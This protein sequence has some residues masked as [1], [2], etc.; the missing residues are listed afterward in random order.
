M[1]DT[2]QTQNNT[3]LDTEF[4]NIVPWNGGFDTGRDVRLKWERNFE[5]IK[6]NFLNLV[7]SMAFNDEKYMRKD[8]PESTQFLLSLLGGAVF[9]EHGFA[10]GITGFGAKIDEKGY[11]EM[12]GLTLWEWLQVPELRYNRV[13]ILIGDKWRG[14]GGGII[15][16]CTPDTDAEGN[17]LDTGTATLKLE[18][19]EYGS[20]HLHDMNM[21]IYHFGDER[22]ATEDSD[23]GKGNFSFAGF[24]TSYFIITEVSDDN[25]G[26]FRY[27]LRA[28]YKIHPYPQM[29]FTCRGN[30]TYEDRMTVVYETRTYTRML[31]KLNT[32]E[33]GVQNIA[34]QFGDLTNLNV[35]GMFMD[36]YS[37]YL[38]SVYFTGTVAQVKPDGTPVMTAND[39]GAW[40]PDDNHADYYDRFSYKGSLWLCID[41]NGTDTTPSENN[42]SWLLQ[43]ESGTSIKILASLDDESQL[44]SSGNSQGDAYLI[45]GDLWVWNGSKFNNVGKIQGP[46]GQSV[47]PMG[48]WYSGLH[49]P[50]L[51]VVRM[52]SST[53]MCNSSDGTD[54][55]PEWCWTDKDGNRFTFSDGGYAL[56]GESNTNEYITIAT[57]GADALGL[58]N[59]DVEYAIGDS[60]TVAPATGWQTIAPAWE[61]GRYIWSRTAMYYK[62]NTMT[63]TDPVCI[64]GGKGIKKITEYYYRSTSAT[65]LVGGEWTSVYP[66]WQNGTYIWTKSVIEYTDGTEDSTDFANVSGAQ[67]EGYTN[68][69]A[70]HTD[71]LV[72]KLG[73]TSMAGSSWTAKVATRNPPMWCWTDKDGNRF[74]F[75]DGGYVLTGERNASEYDVLAQKGENGKDGVI[76]EEIYIRTSSYSIPSTPV[77][78]QSEDYLPSGWT[79]YPSGISESY[80]Y[81]WVSKRRRSSSGIWGAYSTPAIFAQMGKDGL[82][83]CVIRDSE[84]ALNTEYRND[85]NLTDKSIIRYIDVV[86]VRNNAMES[87]WDAYQCLKTHVSSSSITYTNTEYWKKFGTNVAAIFT[88]LIIA[89]NA[90]VRFFQGNDLLIQTEDGIV[91]AGLTGSND[92][93]SIRFFSGSTF[94]N[95]ATAPFRVNRTGEFWATK[96]HI[97]GEIVATSGA[98]DNVTISNCV[99]NSLRSSDNS[100][101]YDSNGLSISAEFSISTGGY[102]L[103]LEKQYADF[104]IKD[105]A[106]NN[107]VRLAAFDDINIASPS[108]RLSHP[109]SGKSALLSVD[110]LYLGDQ[111]GEYVGLSSTGLQFRRYGNVYDGLTGTATTYDGNGNGTR[112]YFYCGILYKI[113]N[114]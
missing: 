87:G 98:F 2:K 31:W 112:M 67:G 50:N 60:N 97:Q 106:N 104:I 56:T 90:K 72:P 88:S 30:T 78:P 19:G 26:T 55:P 59:V 83:G 6:N 11:G 77:S 39:R 7:A 49:V 45:D 76:P 8:I 101:V 53:Y 46:A 108:L 40:P 89:K 96:A 37:M 34:M 29:H 51:G 68:M 21:G 17:I 81:E 43:V 103:K 27:S 92:A 13:E 85:S 25:N 80:P 114:L 95:R 35:F 69:G 79:R 4:E 1:T 73:V 100:F 110:S 16:T 65:E 63:Y 91:D 99:F 10:S 113:T 54:N 82:G 36:G 61:N 20:I 28:G 9:G 41:E 71:L 38:N 14:P 86:L 47:T 5:K 22:D 64:S 18:D 23:D 102:T 111:T 93:G 74:T 109:A 33:I 58:I 42:P 12:R 107:L 57:D 62:D 84:W 52:A 24:A 44:P 48:Y 66:G 105:S 75:S 3:Q 70:W 94:E 32:W 15:E